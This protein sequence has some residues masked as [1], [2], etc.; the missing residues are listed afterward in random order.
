MSNGKTI[1][2]IKALGDQGG[3]GGTSDAVQYIPQELTES[4]QMQARKNLG[5]YYRKADKLYLCDEQTI[6]PYY[7]ESGDKTGG[8]VS[9]IGSVIDDVLTEPPD[10]IYAV[11]N[12]ETHKLAQ[13]GKGMP[14][15]YIYGN[16]FLYS[17]SNPDTGEDIAFGLYD[18]SVRIRGIVS[19]I[20]F[21]AYAE[22]NIVE[23]IPAEYLPGAF[24]PTAVIKSSDYDN[25]LMGVQT[26][27]APAGPTYECIN[28][29]FEDAYQ[30]VRKGF[31]I[32]AVY[33]GIIDE[34]PRYE[35]V[36]DYTDLTN[37]I[38]QPCL[39]MLADVDLFWTEN[40][41]STTEPSAT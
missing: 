31:P 37:Q 41:I 34:L 19:E 40:G 9:V 16:A 35:V 1:G 23:T 27:S 20:S 29:T 5:V 36:R 32:S 10:Y 15:A 18:A 38:G 12:G 7:F 22:T 11:V 3:G 21:S 39:L 30:R 13:S 8:N 33:M 2:L 24:V 4:Q 6:S 14:L 26:A 28:M 25:A 17:A